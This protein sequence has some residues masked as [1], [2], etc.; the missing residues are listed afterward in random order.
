MNISGKIREYGIRNA[1]YSGFTLAEAMMATVVLA[2]AAAGVLLP[3][4][5]GAGL[6]AE[7]NR[8]TLGVKLAGDKMEQIIHMTFD[9]IDGFT[10]SQGEGEV[11]D[12][13]GDVFTDPAYAKFSREV[14]CEPAYVP[15]QSEDGQYNF[16]LVT[17]TVRWNGKDIAT[18]KRLVAE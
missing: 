8:R 17:I 6:R 9:E 4:T 2:I 16:I 12:V 7:G 15:H 5:S 11:T 13:A 14:I 1:E 10:E 18:I 3:F